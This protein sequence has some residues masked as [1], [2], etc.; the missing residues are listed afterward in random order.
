MFRKNQEIGQFWNIDFVSFEISKPDSV[1]VKHKKIFRRSL[2][3]C[4]TSELWPY[5]V[6]KFD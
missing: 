4:E 3:G 1:G 5:G 2:D 6:L